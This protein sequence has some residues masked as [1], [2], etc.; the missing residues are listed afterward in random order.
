[1]A[2]CECFPLW[3][4]EA[5]GNIDPAILPITKGLQAELLQWARRFDDGLSWSDPAR[6]VVS[7][8]DQ[9]AFEMEGRRLADQLRAELGPEWT[10]IEHI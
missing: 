5:V 2:D 9:A 1:M 3:E 10:I 4:V 8:E 7:P 6:T